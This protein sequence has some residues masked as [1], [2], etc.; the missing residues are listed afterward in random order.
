MS[1]HC[2]EADFLIFFLLLP[3]SLAFLVW[4][5]HPWCLCLQTLQN[6]LD[7]REGAG[8]V[9]DLFFGLLQQCAHFTSCTDTYPWILSLFP[10]MATC[11]PEHFHIGS[12]LPLCR[13]AGA[14]GAWREFNNC[15]SV[16]KVPVLLSMK[17]APAVSIQNHILWGFYLLPAGKNNNK[18]K[19][20]KSVSLNLVALGGQVHYTL[21]T[22]ALE[23][24][25]LQLC[26]T[27]SAYTECPK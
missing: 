16:G 21:L 4:T 2:A 15:V 23:M 6:E 11:T 13:A 19:L 18:N 26:V 8:L 17:W 14:W 12:L 3:L 7:G 10:A 22:R 1:L 20:Q 27:L 5:L 25:F 9:M 24:Y